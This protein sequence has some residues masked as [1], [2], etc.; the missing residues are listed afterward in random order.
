M[1]QMKVQPNAL[2]VRSKIY[3]DRTLIS[4]SFREFS[5]HFHRMFG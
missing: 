5:V 4:K 3:P 1:L 2:I